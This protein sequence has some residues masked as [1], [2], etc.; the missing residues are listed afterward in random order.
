MDTLTIQARFSTQEQ[1]ESAVRKLASLRGDRFRIEREAAYAQA[2]TPAIDADQ[3]ADGLTASV[4]AGSAVQSYS[5]VMA[6]ADAAAN[7]WGVG[8][9][10]APAASFTLSANVPVMAAEQARSVLLGA[11]GEMM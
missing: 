10:G 9:E 11:G 8:A 1:A 3:S 7:G 5:G 2:G 6:S 4:L